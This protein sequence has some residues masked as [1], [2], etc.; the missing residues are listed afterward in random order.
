MRQELIKTEVLRLVIGSSLLWAA[1][2]LAQDNAATNNS[3]NFGNDLSTNSGINSTSATVTNAPARSYPRVLAGE[4]LLLAPGL[5]EKLKLTDAQRTELRTIE[6]DFA[7]TSQEYKV[8]NQP[9]IDAALEANRQA[10]ASKDTA[11]IQAAHTQLQEVWEG[12]QPYRV[13]ALN[14]FKLLLTPDQL[15]ILDD[16]KNQWRGNHAAPGNVRS[17]NEPHRNTSV[18]IPPTHRNHRI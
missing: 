11:R 6:D 5:E 7:N 18:V 15:K 1:A 4:Q 9:R 13:A 10:F 12:L 8:A 17:R 16:P 2:L 14:R 3:K